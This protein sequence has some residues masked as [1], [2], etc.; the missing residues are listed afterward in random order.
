M[1]LSTTIGIKFFSFLIRGG[2][3]FHCL[4]LPMPKFYPPFC[5]THVADHLASVP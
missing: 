2:S 3:G 4:A 5:H 1:C